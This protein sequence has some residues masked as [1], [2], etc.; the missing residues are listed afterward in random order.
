[1]WK[2]KPSG[3]DGEE[4]SRYR[5]KVIS[6]R[7][8]QNSTTRKDNTFIVAWIVREY[9]E[10]DVNWDLGHRP[11]KLDC[12]V[13]FPSGASFQLMTPEP[14]VTR[15]SNQTLHV[16]SFEV[17]H[18]FSHRHREVR[19]LRKESCR[20]YLSSSSISDQR[21]KFCLVSMRFFRVL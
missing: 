13:V 11:N 3:T 18:A 6:T 12:K 16:R 21:S 10:I 1:M 15:E 14:C 17:A 9:T 20:V 2:S 8:K 4:H 19:H 5:T 7:Q